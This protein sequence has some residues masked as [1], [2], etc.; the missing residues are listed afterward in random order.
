[1]VVFVTCKTEDQIKNECA[2]VVTTFLPLGVYGDFSRRSREANSAV[3][4]WILPNFE[5]IRD[6]MVVLV[7]CKNEEDPVKNSEVSDGILTK[8]KIIQA[9]IVG[10]VT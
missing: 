6:F 4:C 8:F 2:R 9:F 3:L 5:P 10:L 1:M 7:T